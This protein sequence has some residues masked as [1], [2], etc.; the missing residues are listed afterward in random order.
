MTSVL[1]FLNGKK[2]YISAVVV[3]LTAGAQALG[4]V[5]PDWVYAVEAAAGLGAIRV[6][7]AK[8]A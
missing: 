1:N 8:S 2:T 7:V 5:V 4:Y 6:A 3:A